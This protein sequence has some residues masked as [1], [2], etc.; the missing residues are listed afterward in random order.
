[1]LHRRPPL[2]RA[3]DER[4]EERSSHAVTTLTAA[5]RDFLDRPLHAIIAT[6][7][8]AGQPSQSVVWYAREG[9][10][11]WISVGPESVKARHIRR[12]PRVSVLVLSED[13]SAYL[14]LEGTATFDG[15]VDDA[16]RATLIG[17]YVG[18][19]RAAGWL[20]AHPLP[21]P[22]TRLRIVAARIG[23]HNLA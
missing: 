23:A 21:A 4:H 20:A 5:Q 19:E 10:I 12:D 17:R 11:L 13:G 3:N 15:T 9:D 2:A 6:L 8:A 16:A 22:N 7:D 18:A 1:M 14:R